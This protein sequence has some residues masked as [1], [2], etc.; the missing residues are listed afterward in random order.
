MTTDAARHEQ[1]LARLLRR[2]QL[3][4]RRIERKLAQRERKRGGVTLMVGPA[5][6]RGVVGGVAASLQHEGGAHELDHG[7]DVVRAQRIRKTL[8]RGA[9]QAV[10][11]RIDHYCAAECGGIVVGEG[12]RRRIQEGRGQGLGVAAVAVAE[13]AALVV[14]FLAAGNTRIG[15]GLYGAFSF[16]LAPTCCSAEP[17]RG[18]WSYVVNSFSASSAICC[19]LSTLP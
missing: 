2:R 6:R 14:N 16:F 10:G 4:E 18:G 5:V 8:H 1:A 12:S 9:G 7:G 3:L 13:V 19:S 17:P 11:D 15:F